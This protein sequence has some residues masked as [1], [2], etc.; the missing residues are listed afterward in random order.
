MGIK[1][2]NHIVIKKTSKQSVIVEPEAPK[3]KGVLNSDNITPFSMGYLKNLGDIYP[4]KDILDVDNPISYEDFIKEYQK[5]SGGFN[6][7]KFERIWKI[8]SSYYTDPLMRKQFPNIY[9]MKLDSQNKLWG[10]TKEAKKLVEMGYLTSE[11]EPWKKVGRTVFAPT[12]KGVD[13]ARGWA[14]YSG[15]FY[16]KDKQD[17]L[18]TYDPVWDRKY[19]KLLGVDNKNKKT[20][21]YNFNNKPQVILID[22][23]KNGSDIPNIDVKAILGEEIGRRL[24][25]ANIQPSSYL[26]DPLYINNVKN[27][28]P[29]KEI[30]LDAEVSSIVITDGI[31]EVLNIPKSVHSFLND[32]FGDYKLRVINDDGG[33][34]ITSALIGKWLIIEKDGIFKGFVKATSFKPNKES[35]FSIYNKLP[36]IAKTL[37]KD[38]KGFDE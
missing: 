22:D 31:I 38:R 16:I 34:A 20:I 18:N 12:Y 3:D 26:S 10:F 36:Y 21:V 14:L 9:G 4:L 35:I 24:H 32:K 8:F 7:E 27:I 2:N 28:F 11:Q 30:P 37:L 19:I 6:Q 13:F 33:Q 15:I 25:K 1:T 23:I 5:I 29:L 17:L